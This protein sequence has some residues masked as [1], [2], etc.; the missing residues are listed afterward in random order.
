MFVCLVRRVFVCLFVVFCFLVVCLFACLFGWFAS[1]L[2]GWGLNID[3]YTF[4]RNP[5]P[6]VKGVNTLAQE[7]GIES[8][9]KGNPESTG[10]MTLQNGPLF[11]P[12]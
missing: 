10:F 4:F 9:S 12:S 2:A 8:S 6:S 3:D 5:Y 1:W 11:L 7:M